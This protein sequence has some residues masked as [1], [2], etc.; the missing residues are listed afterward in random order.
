MDLKTKEELIQR[1]RADAAAYC[2]F[3]DRFGREDISK[4]YTTLERLLANLAVSAQDLPHCFPDQDVPELKRVQYQ[5]IVH[6]IN[7]VLAPVVS[8]L[9]E[10]YKDN[11][12]NL[13]TA[14][15]LND[16]LADTYMDLKDGLSYFERADQNSQ[17][18]AVWYWKY[19]FGNHW[20]YHIY[21]A[22]HT[23]HVI[24]GQCWSE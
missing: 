5:D 16:D 20:G 22:L 1:F 13:V 21:R 9:C 3:L 12:E 8:T 6:R 7:P 11:M 19:S 14:T 23:V 18:H 15:M 10:Y 2:D 17:D 24:R 4:L